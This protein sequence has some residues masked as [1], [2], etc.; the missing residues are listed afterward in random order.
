MT[1]LLIQVILRFKE[2]PHAP[3]EFLDFSI[4]GIGLGFEIILL[5]NVLIWILS[6]SFEDGLPHQLI[7]LSAKRV[8][9]LFDF[10]DLL[11]NVRYLLVSGSRAPLPRQK[12]ILPL[13]KRLV[14]VKY[15]LVVLLVTV[16]KALLGPH[17]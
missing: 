1:L 6:G 13:T 3:S 4:F 12:L 10:F 9:L 11:P 17:V 16:E 5:L 8:P 14:L 7:E 2:S 15:R